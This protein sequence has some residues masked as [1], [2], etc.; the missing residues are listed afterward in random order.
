MESLNSKE[1]G[2]QREL[3]LAYL[4]GLL[5][6]EGFI[7]MFHNRPGY[8]V[9]AMKC[10]MCDREGLDLLKQT[11]G[12]SISV[13]SNSHHPGLRPSWQWQ[14]YGRKQVM[15]T[16]KILIPYLIIK[17]R[18][19]QAVLEYCEQYRNLRKYPME[20]LRRREDFYQ[21]IKKLIHRGPA[22]TKPVDPEKGSDSLILGETSGES[23]EVVTPPTPPSRS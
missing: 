11:F 12:G 13:G 9:V 15:S 17:K 5:D 6:G 21:Q 23:L 18:L 8:Y 20:E 3:T 4:A 14:L 16:V 2:N 22:T 1:H 10:H 7:G 19:A